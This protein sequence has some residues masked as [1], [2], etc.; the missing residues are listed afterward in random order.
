MLL[1]LGQDLAA[2]GRRVDTFMV[3]NEEAFS[4]TFLD[5]QRNNPFGTSPNPFLVQ[6]RIK[7]V[8]GHGTKMA[9]IAGG[10]VNGIAPVSSFPS[11]L[12]SSEPMLISSLATRLP[13][14]IS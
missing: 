4:S 9:I 6:P 10:K 12:T 1:T 13:I 11:V 2:Q 7:G 14:Y 8:T 5:D 3:A